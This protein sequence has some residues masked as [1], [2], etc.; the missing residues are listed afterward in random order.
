MREK[1]F[2]WVKRTTEVVPCAQSIA[3]S[4]NCSACT[5]WGREQGTETWK[6]GD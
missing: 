5:P 4:E 2:M 6:K 3:R 1:M